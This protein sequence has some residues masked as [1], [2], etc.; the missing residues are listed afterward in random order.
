MFLVHTFSSPIDIH[1]PYISECKSIPV[2]V[3]WMLRF[4]PES[5][6]LADP[7]LSFSPARINYNSALP[8]PFCAWELAFR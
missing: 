6:S 7:V 2:Q 3:Q 4:N 1:C 5:V 8:K